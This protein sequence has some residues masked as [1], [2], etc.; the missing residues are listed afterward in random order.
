VVGDDHPGKRWVYLY[1][2]A[3]MQNPLSKIAD[4]SAGVARRH[5]FQE[6]LVTDDPPCIPN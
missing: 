1:L 2:L 5:G 6:F 3:E 4:A